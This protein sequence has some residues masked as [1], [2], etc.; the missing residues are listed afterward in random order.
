[1]LI[2]LNEKYSKKTLIL[3]IL[4][5]FFL[6][7]SSSKV[8]PVLLTGK[9]EFHPN[10]EDTVLCDLVSYYRD[11]YALT[12]FACL[13]WCGII[14]VI[15][16]FASHFL[17]NIQLSICVNRHYYVLASLIF[18]LSSQQTIFFLVDE[19]LKI[20][21]CNPKYFF[22]GSL[23]LCFFTC[24]LAMG[25]LWYITLAFTYFILTDNSPAKILIAA[26][27]IPFLV[28][29]L[30]ALY[31][32][33]PL[34]L[35]DILNSDEH[36]ESFKINCLESIGERV[37]SLDIFKAY[38]ISESQTDKNC[39]QSIR[40]F[41]TSAGRLKSKGQPISIGLPRTGKVVAGVGTAAAQFGENVCKNDIDSLIKLFCS[42]K[43]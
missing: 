6:L 41:C 30:S 3:F 43:K 10:S 14:L 24:I 12:I 8:V 39:E 35:L 21:L 7:W 34:G 25:C 22:F 32:L 13:F 26:F 42:P 31:I 15:T 38:C 2:K 4:G 27:L 17:L 20:L 28:P 33:E 36:D 5:L 1:M 29:G 11:F 16:S 37:F 19:F 9:F 23:V 40:D 18:F